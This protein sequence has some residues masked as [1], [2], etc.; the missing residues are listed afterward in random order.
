MQVLILLCLS[1]FSLGALGSKLYAVEIKK[2][3]SGMGSIEFCFDKLAPHHVSYLT[4]P[5]RISIEF[6]ETDLMFKIKDI[7][8]KKDIV[9]LVRSSRPRPEVL[10][11]VFE[12]N[13][14]REVTRSKIKNN[15]LNYPPLTL[16]FTLR[17]QTINAKT[18][19]IEL[20]AATSSQSKNALLLKKDK[21]I[22]TKKPA[23]KGRDIIV[24]L[25]PGHGGKDPGAIGLRKSLEKTVTL[26]I[27]KKLKENINK[28]IGM[29]AILTRNGD[30]YIGLRERLKIA[31][32]NNADIFISIHADAFINKQSRGASIFALSPSGATSEAARW[33]A[34]KENYSELDGVN[35]SELKDRSVQVRNLL[36]D[37]SQTTTINFSLSMGKQVLNA[38][39]KI[40][41]LHNN[42]IE[43]AGFMV[44]KS[45]DIPS[46]LIETG[47]ITNS[48]EE[49]KL[50]SERY[51]SALSQSIVLSLTHF[52]KENP[53][54]GTY[55]EGV[56]EGFTLHIVRKGETLSQISSLYDVPVGT[57]QSINKLSNSKIKIGQSIKV[58]FV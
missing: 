56:T 7:D 24:V 6:E 2:T 23:K 50:T 58:P 17:K 39:G 15:H 13:Q 8:L 55:F 57:L 36:I 45:P 32:K 38:L 4:N 12:L 37:L 19:S 10:R 52:F 21:L 51:Q 1:L 5:S 28:Q 44:L 42:N 41:P 3:N 53:P 35:L 47:F 25:D 33:L 26:S 31:R 34:E 14:I 46:I 9:K 29:R 40:T 30:Y 54:K 49:K 22:I 48:S 20:K 43:Q 18:Q 11:L 16:N 27:A